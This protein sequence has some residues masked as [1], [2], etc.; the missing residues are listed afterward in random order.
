MLLK[1]SAPHENSLGW[2]LL[3][4][5]RCATSCWREARTK[6]FASGRCL[7]AAYLTRMRSSVGKVPKQP[8]RSSVKAM[9]VLE[10]PPNL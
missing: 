4:V 2:R 1:G 5:S 9:Q 8:K 3:Y 6:S 7:I 10:E